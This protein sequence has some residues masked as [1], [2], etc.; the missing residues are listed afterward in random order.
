MNFPKLDKDLAII[1]KLG[2][3]PGA[4]DGLSPDGLKAKFDEAALL[5]QAY[6]NGTLVETLNNIFSGGDSA[7]SNGLNMAGPINMNRNPLQNLR[8]PESPGEA[9]NLEY[10]LAHFLTS[11][12]KINGKDLS[13]DITLSASDIG[14]RPDTWLPTPAE[15]GAAPESHVDNKDNPHK[16]TCEKIG[17]ATKDDVDGKISMDLLWVN[18][19]FNSNFA[20]QTI[21]LDLSGY[22]AVMIT[23]SSEATSFVP[24]GDQG[25]ITTWNGYYICRRTVYTSVDGVNFSSATTWSQYGNNVNG[26]ENP[27]WQCRPYKIYGFKGVKE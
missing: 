2:D 13:S 27:S 8:N 14:A 1:S 20:E 9:V 22:D 3:N 25:A 12:R 10:A 16:V 23:A 19:S 15:L 24:V 18:A 7:P 21:A 11:A 5:I 26:A 4:D 17:A 6:L